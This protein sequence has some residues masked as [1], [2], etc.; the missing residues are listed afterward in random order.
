MILSCLQ[1][2]DPVSCLGN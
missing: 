1:F 2:T